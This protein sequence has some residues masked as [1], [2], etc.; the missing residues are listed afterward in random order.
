MRI[1]FPELVSMP[2]FIK[3]LGGSFDAIPIP[4]NKDKQ[5]RYFDAPKQYV[6]HAH[7]IDTDRISNLAAGFLQ[8]VDK[9]NYLKKLY[10]S[11]CLTFDRTC[12][13]ILLK[14]GVDEAKIN[15]LRVAYVSRLSGELQT[16]VG[17]R[18][19]RL[20]AMIASVYNSVYTKYLQ[21]ESAYT[22]ISD[23]GYRHC[24]KY[25]VKDINSA[26]MGKSVRKGA[27]PVRKKVVFLT[28]DE[29][30]KLV[31]TFYYRLIEVRSKINKYALE[32]C[33]CSKGRYKYDESLSDIIGKSEIVCNQSGGQAFPGWHAA[34]ATA[35]TLYT[36]LNGIQARMLNYETT[37]QRQF[38]QGV[39]RCLD[40]EYKRR[41]IADG[42]NQLFQEVP[43]SQEGPIK[44]SDI[45]DHN[46]E[47]KSTNLL[48]TDVR[49]LFEDSKNDAK[50]AFEMT[51]N[52]PTTNEHS[53][54]LKDIFNVLFFWLP[55]LIGLFSEA[56]KP[57]VKACN[58]SR[59]KEVASLS[60]M[61]GGKP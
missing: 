43:I 15:R 55:P 1:W 59:Y 11:A 45:N 53:L 16:K 14:N 6:V 3:G 60:S 24:L 5:Y 50:N 26:L 28:D 8:S 10:L 34:P 21:E 25:A 37:I 54:F 30:W 19:P 22:I 32:R 41:T 13:E 18:S 47:Y 7:E 31:Q 42:Q 57:N 48:D 44:S 33:L 2:P 4:E 49:Q 56:K 9:A 46:E 61:C 29:N 58:T 23:V 27:P 52:N 35:A 17:E 38:F 39:T 51:M 20:Q 36:K 12:L 40:G